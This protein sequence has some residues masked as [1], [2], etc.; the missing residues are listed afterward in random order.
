MVGDDTDAADEP[1]AFEEPDGVSGLALAATDH[2][3]LFSAAS[4]ETSGDDASGDDESG[5]EASAE[6]QAE[7]EEQEVI[8]ETTLRFDE[9]E[10][11][12]A[13]TSD[14]ESGAPEFDLDSDEYA[15]FDAD[16]AGTEEQPVAEEP[17]PESVKGDAELQNLAPTVAAE[18]LDEELV[19]IFVEEAEEV[20]ETITEW[21]QKWAPEFTDADAL[22]EVRRGF[23]TLK[24]SG[25]MVGAEAVGELAWSV[26]NMLNRVVD[27]TVAATPDF[28]TVVDE[29]RL[30]IP[31][32]V[33]MFAKGAPADMSAVT[34]TMERADILASG[35]SI[36]AVPQEAPPEPTIAEEVRVFLDEAR[37]LQSTVAAYAAGGTLDDDTSRALH[38]LVGSAGTIGQTSIHQV[39]D[40]AYQVVLVARDDNFSDADLEGP[41]RTFVGR[42]AELL[43]TA[44]D[45]LEAGTDVAP[46]KEV[47]NERDEVLALASQEEEAVD[48]LVTSDALGAVLDAGEQL[49]ELRSAALSKEAAAALGAAFE[50]V[51]GL[52]RETSRAQVADLVRALHDTYVEQP[53]PFSDAAYGV[54]L[55]AHERLVSL[56]DALV[57]DERLPR[58]DDVVVALADLKRQTAEEAAHE[59]A[60]EAAQEAAQ[61]SEESVAEKELAQANRGAR[62]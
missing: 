37:P 45:A 51:E 27:G 32:L 22:A 43:N 8:D 9:D 19:E 7:L 53:T 57:S 29:A 21:S 47:A 2:E 20:L 59:A 26:E 31:D 38:T 13:L 55:E 36:G 5:D 18:E 4:D 17:A 34:T 49:S 35:G 16:V 11:D 50:A 42:C 52:A 60:H 14:S 48:P 56:I 54:I 1:K 6:E 25:R 12:E 33:E 15:M 3:A 62:S 28:A 58:V 61:V 10:A 46:A 30:L 41:V 40:A 23:H 24:G 44:F 39:A